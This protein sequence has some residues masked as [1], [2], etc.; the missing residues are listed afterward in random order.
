MATYNGR[1]HI[2]R[3]LD[4]LAA[5]TLIPAEL[6]ITDDGSDDDTIS[7]VEE[8]AKN[9]PF[10][11]KVFRNEA[12]LGYRKNFM[13]AASLCQSDLIA[14]CHF[15]LLVEIMRGIRRLHISHAN[16]EIA[17]ALT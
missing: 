11:V 4:S 10:A 17:E 12:R 3:Q 5:Q 2:R 8:F 1:Q 14:F 9:A 6:V 13:R 16:G 15:G 7:V